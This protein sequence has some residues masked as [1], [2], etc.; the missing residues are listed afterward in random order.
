MSIRVASRR[1][2]MT[3]LT[4][5]FPGAE[6]IDVTSR[7]S[8]PWVRLSPFYPH[9]G[10]PVPYCDGVTSQS[11]EGIWQ[12]LKVFQESDV[13]PAKLRIPTMKGLKRTV[14]RHGPVQG[15]RTGL[16]GDQLLPYETARRRIYLPAY[17]WVL[18]HRVA[19]LVDRLRDK[20]DVVLLDYTTNGDVTDPASPLSHAAL[21]QLH[22]EGRWPDEGDTML[23]T[24]SAIECAE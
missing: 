12:A 4:T 2:A 10:I 22:I 5:A 9:G 24:R 14:R 3:S 23:P 20:K 7:A 1:R 19:D 13:D 18:E 11:V 17:R 8:E 21:I 16:H 15:H 6:I